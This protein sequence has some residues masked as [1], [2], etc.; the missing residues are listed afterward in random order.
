MEPASRSSIS[1]DAVVDIAVVPDS[2]SVVVNEVF[3]FDVYVYPNA[4]QVD[5]VDA[6]IT[7]DPTYLEVQSIISDTSGLDLEM[8]SDFNNSAGTLTHSGGTFGPSFPDSTFRLCSISLRAT[9]ATTGTTLAFT[10]VTDAYFGGP[11]V[12][13]NKTNGTVE[14]YDLDG[15][16]DV[17]MAD[18]MLVAVRWRTSCETP[19]PDDDPA[20]PNYDWSYDSDGDCDI[21]IVDIMLV[22]VRWTGSGA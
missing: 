17:D 7:F 22:A 20:T 5:S 10:A 1:L 14:N 15:D 9:A 21:D 11:S 3:T 8:H 18:I 2:K 19:D 13:R 4:Q 6:D 16:G 12:L